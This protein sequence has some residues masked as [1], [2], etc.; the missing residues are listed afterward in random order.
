M[1][2]H[3]AKFYIYNEASKYLE[4]MNIDIESNEMIQNCCVLG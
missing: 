4:T 1:L 2:R 3:N